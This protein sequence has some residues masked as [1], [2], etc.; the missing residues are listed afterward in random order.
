M[1][2][3]QADSSKDINTVRQT[4]IALLKTRTR[5]NESFR[6]F[7][8]I[9]NRTGVGN[10]WEEL[11]KKSGGVT[12]KIDLYRREASDFLN[13]LFRSGVLAWGNLEVSSN[14]DTPHFYVT[15]QGKKSLEAYDRDPRNPNGYLAHLKSI[16]ELDEAE[17][18]YAEEAAWSFTSCR[19]RAAAVMI[20]VAAESLILR[21]AE[22]IA[23][24]KL[25]SD[26]L[27]AALKGISIKLVLRELMTI[28]QSQRPALKQYDDRLET[29]LLDGKW[30]AFTETIRLSRNDAGHPNPLGTTTEQDVYESLVLFPDLAVLVRDVRKWAKLAGT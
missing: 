13:E 22:E 15:D 14:S 23:D 27:K 7:S 24:G 28:F 8:E 30:T 19:H 21:L 3:D 18:S 5:R 9:F 2:A 16:G 29:R 1:S 11:L 25:G 20:G 26:K 6:G 10:T 4:V 12:P 17:L